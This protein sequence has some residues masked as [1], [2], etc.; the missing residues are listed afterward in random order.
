MR[1]SS[2]EKNFEDELPPFLA[3]VLKEP[4]KYDAIAKSEK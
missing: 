1:L 3:F 2:T 4:Q